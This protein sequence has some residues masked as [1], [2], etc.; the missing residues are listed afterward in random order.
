M[1]DSY[2]GL[3]RNWDRLRDPHAAVAYLNRSVVNGS[4]SRLRHRATVRAFR[5]PAA[6]VQPSAEAGGMDIRRR[7]DLAAAVRNYRADS[8]RW[9]C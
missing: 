4:H 2:E 7:H 6:G 5:R 3:Y 8:A 9:W 1:Q